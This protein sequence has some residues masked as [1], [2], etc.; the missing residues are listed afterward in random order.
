M[1]AMLLCAGMAAQAA[2]PSQRFTYDDLMKIRSL[3][4]TVAGLRFTNDG[5]H[6]TAIV[7]GDVCLYSVATGEAMD[8]LYDAAAMPDTVVVEDYALSDDERLMLVSTN[9][10]RIYRR[11]F[12]ADYYVV[13]LAA[14][15]LM[16]VAPEI[17]GKRDAAFSPDGSRIAFVSGNNLYVADITADGVS[18][19]RALTTDGVVNSI[20]NGATDFVYEEEFAFTRAFEFSPD[21]TRI[22]Y[23]RFDESEVEEFEMMRYDGKLYNTPYKFKYPKAGERNSTVGLYV[24]DLSSGRTSR[25]DTGTETDQYISRIGWAPNGEL[26]FFRLNRLQNHF[27]VVMAGADGTQQVIYDE[28]SPRYVERT[29]ANSVTFLPDGD[30]FIVRNETGSG[31]MHLYLYSIEK[32]LVRALTSGEWEVTEVA[33]VADGRVYYL[34]TETSPLQRNLYSVDMKGRNKRRLTDRDG[35][36]SIVAGPGMHYF[37]SYF[38][39]A[40]E[41]QTV[42][43]HR[44]DG[45]VVRV[46]EENAAYREAVASLPRKEFFSFETERGD[47]LNGYMIRPTDF[48]STKR[49]PVLMTQYSGPGSQSVDDR[50]ALDWVDVMVQ[51]GYVVFCVDGRGTGF[52]GEEFKKCTYGDLGRLETEDQISAARYIASLPWVD[53]SRIGIY[54]WSYGGFMALNAALHGG[55]LFRMAIAVAPV[56]SWRY[57]DT[58][59][60]ELYN[61]LPQDN[62]AGYDDNSPI[63]FADGLSDR[64]SLLIIHGTGDDN[65]HFQ[66]TVE[67]VR[68]LD[69]AGKLFDLAIYPD[70]NHSMIPAGRNHIYRRMVAYTLRNL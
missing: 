12:T 36:Y 7:G 55:D 10:H 56:T 3:N 61:G 16:A 22:A 26:Y 33:G 42:T 66:N 1:A 4:R 19:A 31:F 52:R 48:D 65:V 27:E 40:D 32:G 39:S 25:V 14:G 30:R 9:H 50:W 2:E 24:Y 57:Y 64:T 53:A 45:E 29:D 37:V 49:Y 70:D 58:V 63:N 38:S 47:R 20:I 28:R 8:T 41:P 43:L 34:S 5:E 68:A 21:G 11:S 15:R 6:Y 60:T 67:M 17:A 59:Y 46:L 54:G 69:S 13:D 51:N 62:A 44:G 18:E 35:Y 23:L